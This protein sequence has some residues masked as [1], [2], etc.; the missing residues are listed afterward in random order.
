VRCCAG[1]PSR[2]LFDELTDFLVLQG[3]LTIQLRD[4][5]LELDEGEL[6]N[7]ACASVLSP[8]PVVVNSSRSTSRRPRSGMER[9]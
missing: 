9:R 8:N 6:F 1:V 7:L 2:V 4:G 5:D 3:H